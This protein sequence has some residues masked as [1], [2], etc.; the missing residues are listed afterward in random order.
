MRFALDCTLT[1][2]DWQF[3]ARRAGGR[4]WENA[5]RN[6]A[7]EHGGAVVLMGNDDV[8]VF[9]RENDGRIL[10]RKGKPQ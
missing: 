6:W 3:A 10:K 5:A 9:S 8:I 2:R 4:S 7:A 1:V